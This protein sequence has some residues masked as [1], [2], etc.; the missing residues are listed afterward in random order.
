MNQKEVMINHMDYALQN[1]ANLVPINVELV[2]L[3]L[4]MWYGLILVDDHPSM[5]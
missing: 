5:N 4:V 2:I 1:V 3:V